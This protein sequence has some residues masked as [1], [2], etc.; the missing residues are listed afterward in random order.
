[1]SPKIISLSHFLPF[2]NTSIKTV[3][4]L[5][6]HL[7]YHQWS[8]FQTELITLGYSRKSPTRRVQ[9]ILFWPPPGIFRSAT[10]PWEIPEKTG[11]HPWKFCRIV[12]HPL[13]I[14]R[15]KTKSHRKYTIHFIHPWKFHFFFNWSLEFPLGL[16]SITLEILKFHVSTPPLFGFFCY[17]PFWGVLARNLPKS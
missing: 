2:H 3:A 5:M 6:H 15:S 17:S 8:K 1:M 7:A 10:L 13:E 4:Y 14:S 11:F 16:S 12:W 9:G